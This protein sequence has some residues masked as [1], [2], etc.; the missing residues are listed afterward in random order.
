MI[1]TTLEHLLCVDTKSSLQQL[2]LLEIPFDVLEA[3]VAVDEHL[4]VT[5]LYPYHGSWK[6]D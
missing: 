4:A 1:I 2:E 6:I 5:L 3:V